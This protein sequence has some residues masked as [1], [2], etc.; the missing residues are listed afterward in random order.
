M[1]GLSIWHI[2]ILVLVVVAF[3]GR[4]RLAA[5]MGEFGKGIGAFKKEIK[6]DDTPKSE[7]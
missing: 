5:L 6:N 4:G 2:L 3:F 1:F 7:S